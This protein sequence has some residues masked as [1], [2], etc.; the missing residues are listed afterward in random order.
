MKLNDRNI[1]NLNVLNN[2]SIDKNMKVSGKP[3]LFPS[4]MH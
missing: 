1:V 4:R 2:K 3:I